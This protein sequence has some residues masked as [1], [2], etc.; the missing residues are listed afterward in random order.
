MRVRGNDERRFSIGTGMVSLDAFSLKGRTALVIGGSG[1]I[2]RQ[3]AQGFRRA[4]A[5]VLVAGRSQT[6]LDR[7]SAELGQGSAGRIGYRADVC[8]LDQLRELADSVAAEHRPPDILVNCQG[9]IVIKPALDV[10]EEEYMFV[11]D[12]NL[13]SVFFA[14]CAFGRLML[15]R[16]SGTIINITS[17]SAHSGWANAAIYSMS[18][19]GVASLTQTLAAEWA[20]GGVR[21]NAITPGFFLTDLNRERMPEERKEEARRRTA[22]RRMGEVSELVGAAIFLASDASGFVTG[23][24]LRVDGGYLSSGI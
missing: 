7:I 6:K 5:T 17:L 8:R 12:T 10:T 9:T 15:A 11:L 1:G 16:G 23:A 22:M 2:G 3:L 13:K 4:G 21:V 19:W 24:I 18:K 14:C 20:Q